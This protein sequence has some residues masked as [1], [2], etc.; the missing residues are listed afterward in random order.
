MHLQ[1]KEH[2]DETHSTLRFASRAKR[3]VNNAVVNEVRTLHDMTCDTAAY[4]VGWMQW[5][6]DLHV[7]TVGW[8]VQVVSDA[9]VLKR[10]AKEIERLMRKLEESGYAHLAPKCVS[11]LAV[12][13]RQWQ[14]QRS[15]AFWHVKYECQPVAV[16]YVS[17]SMQTSL[18]LLACRDADVQA[19]IAQLRTQLL[20]A[21]QARE[22]VQ[23]QLVKEKEEREHAQRKVH[24]PCYCYRPAEMLCDNGSVVNTWKSRNFW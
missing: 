16:Q 20:Q 1:A 12:L 3:V 23:E 19:E 5:T 9:A 6:M 8:H 18:T 24:A 11:Y 15:A 4:T 17:L 21:D 10:Q 13:H 7:L 22:L 14:L 2:A